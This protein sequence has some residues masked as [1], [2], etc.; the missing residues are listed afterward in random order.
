MND[1]S[2]VRSKKNFLL[3]R[4]YGMSLTKYTLQHIIR[5]QI[6]RGIQILDSKLR[7]EKNLTTKSKIMTTETTIMT[8]ETVIVTT[9]TTIVT[10]EATNLDHRSQS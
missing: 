3:H 10:L 1:T 8:T 9:E 2:S 7:L 6:S 5:K 4:K